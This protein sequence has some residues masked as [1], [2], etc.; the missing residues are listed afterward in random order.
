M[1]NDDYNV[2]YGGTFGGDD[3][4]YHRYRDDNSNVDDVM[5]VGDWIGT[6]IILS[7]PIVNI[8]MYFLWAFGDSVNKNKKNFAKATL[9]LGAMGLV[10]GGLL[11]SCSVI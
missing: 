10:L 3:I 2:K 7:I 5:T 1:Y 9:I 6:M 4:N 11:A 8:I